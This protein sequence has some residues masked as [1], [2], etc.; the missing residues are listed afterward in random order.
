MSCRRQKCIAQA[1]ERGQLMRRSRGDAQQ[2]GSSASGKLRAGAACCP[3]KCDTRPQASGQRAP[4]L[5]LVRRRAAS[6]RALSRAPE[7]RSRFVPLS[8]PTS[9]WPA[10]HGRRS[11]V[12]CHPLANTL[13]L[14]HLTDD[15]FSLSLSQLREARNLLLR[16]LRLAPHSCD[17]S[18]P[19]ARHCM[20]GRA[21]PVGCPGSSCTQR[22][23]KARVASF[24]PGSRRSGA[25]RASAHC[26][27]KTSTRVERKLRLLAL[28][29]DLR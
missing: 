13:P 9:R 16:E 19:G 27:S 18:P 28:A 7:P 29:S 17:L 10:A 8:R 15:A 24:A 6:S 26:S 25:R 1:Q 14:S 12:A 20:Q 21:L 11:L 4:T 3:C 5:A 23:A 2:R 22:G